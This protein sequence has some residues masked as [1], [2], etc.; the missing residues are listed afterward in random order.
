MYNISYN[1]L[2]D[3]KS[4][5]IRFNKIVR[6]IRVYDGTTYLVLFGSEKYDFIYNRIRYLIGVKSGLCVISH[7]YAKTKVDSYHSLSLENTMTFYNVIMFI[8]SIFDKDKNNYYYNI[9]LEK[10]SYKFPKK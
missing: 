5:R 8:K 4:L 2:I 10:A 9:F 1:T 6:F 3:A 7:N